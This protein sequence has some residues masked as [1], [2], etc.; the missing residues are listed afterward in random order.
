MKLTKKAIGLS[1]TVL[2][3]A[4][5]AA[6][7][8]AQAQELDATGM[9]M[10]VGVGVA[11][12]DEKDR[13]RFG[14]FNGLRT[15]K[16]NAIL[17]FGYLDGDANSGRWFSV[18]GRNLGLDNAELGFSYRRLGDLKL[19]GEYSELTRHDPRTINTAL[20][21][22]G[23]TTPTVVGL[24]AP[25]TGAERNLSLKRKGISF[26][27]EKWF[28]GR[29]QMEVSF[30]NEE[31]EG[32]R[33]FG[34]GYSCTANSAQLAANPSCASTNAAGT[35]TGNAIF[36]LPEPVNSTHRQ[37]EVKLN[38][39][40]DRLNLTG[41][42]YASIYTN[43]NGNI[44]PTLPATGF[45]NVLG[46]SSVGGVGV[47]LD[48]VLR[49]N[50]QLPIALWPDNQAQ[51]IYLSGN[52]KVTAG[53][54]INFKYAYTHAKQ[55][56]GFLNMGL[57][58][59]PRTSLGGE[60]NSTKA[61]IG[62]SAHPLKPLHLHGDLKYED[63]NDKTPIA[64][65]NTERV[66]TAPA[67]RDGV[68]TNG[69]YSPKKLHGKLEA[70]Y[71]LPQSLLLV[72]GVEYEH[73]DL[74]KLTETVNVAG[75]SGIRQKLEE[76]GYRLELKKT[77]SETFNGSISY[78]SSERKGDSP[79]LK[80]LSLSCQGQG[81]LSNAGTGAIEA[82]VNLLSVTTCATFNNGIAGLSTA[83]PIFPFL[84]TDRKRDKLK[85]MGTWTPNERLALTFFVE[86]GKDGYTAPVS[87]HGLR[88]TGFRMYSADLS[89]AVSDD[90]KVNAYASRG[91]YK[92]SAGH[93]TGYDATLKD[94]ADSF[95][96]GFS[97]RLAGRWM[98]GGDLTYLDDRLVYKQDPDPNASA[99]N[100]AYLNAVGGLPDVTYQLLRLKLFGEYRVD[101]Q[102]SVRLDLVHQR[103]KFNEW[104][105][106]YNGTPFFYNDNTTLSAKENQ[107]V[108]YFG[109]SY[110]Y[111]YR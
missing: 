49:A 20:V 99:N 50:M 66:G 38:W 24:A 51:Q 68:F 85:A 28:D 106:S 1:Q 17:G 82:D 15:E 26:S 61:Q 46:Q 10:S 29:L 75:L 55:N 31:K 11:T 63:R 52:Y 34:I 108:T 88:D 62:F 25:G 73:E 77:M 64:L 111:R 101:K 37:V 6:F 23:T 96:V 104:T 105:W 41:G 59:G 93:S 56:E 2:S 53:T 81:G 100:K 60:V 27:G 74:G 8:P 76:T 35:I 40:G 7:A 36:M 44:T 87:D 107:S 4:V 43:A 18:E 91:D 48:P 83:R 69:Q 70:S 98:V 58:G 13:A 102:S 86:D 103:T 67:Y 92:T 90:W 21:G 32:A 109:A 65:Y 19:S 54:R 95:G 39:A 30:K 78:K 3:L 42:Y 22:L 14:M 89:Y 5:L 57:P 110:V 84:F 71:K 72:G 80:L 9:T 12:G 16:G 79:W 33:L 47:T 45:V 94:T 97:G